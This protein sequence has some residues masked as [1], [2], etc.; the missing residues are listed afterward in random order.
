MTGR[1]P[2]MWK[3]NLTVV[4][5]EPRN[6]LNIGAAARAMLNFGFSRLALVAPYDVAFREARSAPG[7]ASVLRNASVAAALPLAVAGCSLVVG[8]SA[9]R[10]RDLHHLRRPLPEAASLLAAH[11][12]RRPAALLFG[13]EKFGLS[14]EHL[15][16][17]RW[18][19]TIPTSAECP[20]MNLGQAVALCCYE[21]ARAAPA[22]APPA[23]GPRPSTVAQQ[24]RIV[25]KLL[26]AQQL[27]GY[28]NPRTS[29]SHQI[30]ARRLIARM[31]LSFQ[32][33]QVLEGIFRQIEWKLGRPGPP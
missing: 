20:S 5:V 6:P 33:A 30:K 24:E 3:N 23:A 27:S 9:A 12:R 25:E 10:R 29:R 31:A 19:L 2:R 8:T 22:S 15:S 17:C 1:D 11:L 13:S 14:N 18:I 4:L 32:D 16:H 28:L 26:A 7:A 21:L